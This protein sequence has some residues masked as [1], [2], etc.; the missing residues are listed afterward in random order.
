M[1]QE[2]AGYVGSG[3]YWLTQADDA[4]HSQ[5]K[6]EYNDGRHIGY[7]T[8]PPDYVKVNALANLALAY[9]AAAKAVDDD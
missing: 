4:A 5:R 1:S 9:F 7:T 2:S 6:A 8:T 3:E